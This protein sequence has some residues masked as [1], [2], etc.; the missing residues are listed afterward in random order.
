M[1]ESL[2]MRSLFQKYGKVAGYVLLTLLL[3]LYFS[4]L[5]FPYDTLKDRY[6]LEGTQ[7][8]PFRVSVES[9]R[10]TPLLWIRAT[11]IQVLSNKPEDQ[12]SL[13]TL[14]EVRLRPSLLRLL[15]GRLAFRVKA[16]LYGGKIQGRAGKG[17]DTVDLAF[18]WK[19]IALEKLP[20]QAQLGGAEL[21]GDL[22]GQMDLRL[23]LQGNRL[24][25][26]EGTFKGRLA[27]GA[28]KNVQF[29]G[30]PLPALADVT[31]EGEVTLGEN[32]LN[33]ESLSVNADLINFSL[34]GKVDL[35]RMLASSPLNLK[36]KVKLA[37][38]LASQYQS[39]LA[40]LLRKQDKEGFY[41]FSIRGTL[42]SPRFSL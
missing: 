10:A 27:G 9:L 15:T 34:E 31:G 14:Q 4:V 32:R 21:K 19:D 13:L 38:S 1:G 6:L 7:G 30:F 20:V 40:G 25:P 39:M 36:G 8:L 2:S 22:S 28:V 12:T 23:R 42:N 33:V 37:G 3:T 24:L 17:K 41:V 29:R 16:F 26:G 11:G 5:T 35:S 18:K